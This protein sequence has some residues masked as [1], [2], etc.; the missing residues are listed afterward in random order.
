MA[1]DP[2]LIRMWS[3]LSTVYAV[4]LTLGV[5][6]AL[7]APV[8]VL[9]AGALTAMV[10]TV[11]V[12][13]PRPRDQ[14]LTLAVGVPVALAVMA[15]G[16][17]LAPYR[18]V[19]DVVFV[20]L[21][22]TSLYIRRLG[23]RATALGVFSFQLFF[24][25]Q[26]V[27]TRVEQLPQL[28]LAVLVAFTSSALVR[29]AVLRSPPGRTLARLQ[30]A[31]QLRLMFVVDALIEVADG[32]RE[33]PRAE[34]AVGDLRR[35]TARLHTAAL[36]IQNRLGAGTPDERTAT[37]IQRRVADAETAVERLAILVLRVLEPGADVDTL[38]PHLT[39]VRP[40]GSAID[41]RDTA[42]LPTLASQLR[43][44]RAAIGPGPL[45]PAGADPAMVRD[46]L[47]GYRNDEHLPDASPA[48]QDAF[49]SAG[50]LARALSGL[51]LAVHGQT[52]ALQEP[53][54]APR[55][56]AELTAERSGLAT[57]AVP[58]QQG[59]RIRPTTRT[60]LQVATGSALAVVGGELLSPERWYWAVFT[61][62]VV[63]IGTTSTGEI[64]VRGYRRLIG[65]VTGVAAGLALAALIGDASWLAFALAG[66]SVFG[67]YYTLA[68][69]YTLMSFFVTT[70]IG[71]LYT[72]LHTLT[73]GL[74][75]VRIEE[76]ALGIACGLAAALL[77]LPVR[78]RERTDQLLRD[79]LERLR[80][81]LSESLAQ[82]RGES[83]GDLL[84]PA[85][86]LDAALDSLRMS[87]QPLITPI[88]PLRSRRRT[89]LTVL[90][91]LETAA[92]HT[93]SLAA[94]AELV[95][96]GPHIGADPRLVDAACRIDRNLATLINQIA[97]QGENNTTLVR[98]PGVPAQLSVTEGAAHPEDI[99]ATRR[100]LRHLHRVDASIQDLARTLHQPVHGD[101]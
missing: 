45:H 82:L 62:W 9:V 100:V 29:F 83:G 39:K 59:P 63:F 14:A 57:D 92:F 23:P 76:T 69:S 60:A 81:V 85:R 101:W 75:V 55:L 65:T 84:D 58:Q 96:A 50:D 94:T 43:A 80:A 42:T 37:A 61:C 34:R 54:A 7:D 13:E 5:L 93:R 47:L 36:M 1:S 25:T 31:F 44:L 41:T 48:M 8:P 33:G 18:V 66:L 53:P 27:E 10:S 12:I 73:P 89:A 49:R 71:M 78:T 70:M 32:K 16:S 20:L 46:R 79:V 11:A 21:I 4:L 72:L 52:P 35:R 38:T 74:L 56:R 2:G 77:V 17:A 95:P 3:A 24:V 26:F 86:A 15:A 99:N 19:A 64:L 88:S 40:A 6:A 51:H 68:V 91:L 22:F 90:G 67:M 28:F 87:V 98:G 97:V 30:R